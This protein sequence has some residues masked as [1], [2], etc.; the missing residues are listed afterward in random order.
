MRK[1]N[2]QLK[3]LSFFEGHDGYGMN[4]DIW[5]DGVKC[6][7]V[8]DAAFGGCYDYYDYRDDKNS[9]KDAKIK[10]L[11]QELNDYIKSLPERE[12]ELSGN[13][14]KFKPDLDTF[15]NDLAVAE[16][17]KKEQ[18]RFEKIMQQAILI[19]VPNASRFMQFKF[20]MPLNKIP[21]PL[22]QGHVNQIKKEHCTEG[23]VILNTNLEALGIKA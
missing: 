13:K 7:H 17:E 11:I 21:T 16:Q 23:K 12:A 1:P 22:L 4:A 18:K 14:F 15:I 20:K 2:V 6:M 10:Q 5:I 19:G 3:K 9:E 8:H